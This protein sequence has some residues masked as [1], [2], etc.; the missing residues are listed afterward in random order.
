VDVYDAASAACD[1]GLLSPGA[2]PALL[3][4]SFSAGEPVRL[5]LEKGR[6]VVVVSTF[7]DSGGTVVTGSSCNLV[8]LDG[9]KQACLEIEISEIDGGV[10]CQ[11]AND[12]CPDGQYC[13]GSLCV[14][15]CKNSAECAP[16]LCNPA[17]HQCVECVT[18]DD[19]P[20]GKLC[21]TSGRCADGCDAARPCAGGLT[22]CDSVCIDTRSDVANCGGCGAAC[23]G[24]DTLCCN[25]QCANPATSTVHCGGC[26][27]A[28]ST[29][30]GA[31]VCSSGS[32]SWSCT[33]G[34]AH[35]M[36]GNTGCD[37][38]IT[39]VDNCGGCGNACNPMNATANRCTAGQC[40]YDCQ[41]T[42]LDCLKVGANVDGCESDAH[43]ITSCGVCGVSCDTTHS[44]GAACP[45]TTCTYTGCMAG[46]SDCNMTTGNADGCEFTDA[47]HATGVMSMG[48]AVSYML[49]CV[50][51]GMPGIA[52][53]YTKPMAQAACAAWIAA[54]GT[55]S[56]SDFTCSGNVDCVRATGVSSC[57][58]WCYT[59]ST[60]G[61]VS[62]AAAC[63]CPTTGS[64]SWN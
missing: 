5:S 62:N 2:G 56:C 31:P 19:C 14:P 58:T 11:A 18:V 29:L 27:N 55:G 24:G 53:T 36:T 39:T 40:A 49:A 50:P 15:G 12:Q 22:C 45:T 13:Q 7:A 57:S 37:T 30:N 42:A 52:S 32:C 10:G 4:R 47:S 43:A 63:G 54:E 26:G 35:C 61:R 23:T 48:T 28:C 25:S 9:G 1:A 33:S 41:P 64:A 3:S 17:R 16:Q 60:A 46:Y 59:K 34:F 20:S 44:I 21:S 51:L 6:R 38:D 8:E